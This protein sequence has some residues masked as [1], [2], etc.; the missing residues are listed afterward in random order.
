[1]PDVEKILEE[2]DR[3]RIELDAARTEE[4]RRSQ[5]YE[6]LAKA[7]QCAADEGPSRIPEI[8]GQIRRGYAAIQ[9]A[10]SRSRELEERLTNLLDELV[11]ASRDGVKNSDS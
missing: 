6:D 7:L 8:A 5:E 4:K 10:R 1:M 3:L 2:R 9:T 11:E